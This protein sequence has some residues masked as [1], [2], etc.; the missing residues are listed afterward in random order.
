MLLSVSIECCICSNEADASSTGALGKD[1]VARCNAH[2]E[3]LG[4]LPKRCDRC[5]PIGPDRQPHFPPERAFFRRLELRIL[6]GPERSQTRG[7]DPSNRIEE[8]SI[9]AR[10]SDA[11]LFFLQVVPD[12]PLEVI[13]LPVR[14][15]DRCVSRILYTLDVQQLY[16]GPLARQT[17]EGQPDVR[18]ALELDAQSQ[19]VHSGSLLSISGGVSLPPYR[20]NLAL[21]RLGVAGTVALRHDSRTSELLWR[22]RLRFRVAFED[23]VPTSSVRPVRHVSAGCYV[24]LADSL[25]AMA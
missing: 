16:S 13:E 15:E 21:Q 11:V 9:V 3:G 4:P 8:L 10:A 5:P 14:H 6:I 17:L 2:P 19:L 24:W 7:S 12:E 18:K 23:E 22:I 1:Q 25:S 20:F